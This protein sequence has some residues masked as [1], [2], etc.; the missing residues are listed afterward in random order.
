MER[1]GHNP[2]PKLRQLSP[3]KIFKPKTPVAPPNVKG[4]D[5]ALKNELIKIIADKLMIAFIIALAGFLFNLFLTH[6]KEEQGFLFQ[7]N[8]TRVERLAEVW[9]KFYV[10]EDEVN[11]RMDELVA[12]SKENLAIVTLMGPVSQQKEEIDSLGNV[13]RK[14]LIK[15]RYWIT[16]TEFDTLM[17]YSKLLINIDSIT[18]QHGVDRYERERRMRRGNIFEIQ[19]QLLKGVL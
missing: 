12:L 9:E 10:V 17:S 11:D 2:Y 14:N 8:K 3:H 18:S 1:K 6:Y 15:N 4:M 5:R 13:L 16:P 19:K 7:L